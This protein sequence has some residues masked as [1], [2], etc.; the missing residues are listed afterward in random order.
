M[1]GGFEILQLLQYV[2]RI[3]ITASVTTRRQPGSLIMHFC[4]IYLQGTAKVRR[5]TLPVDML[6]V[7][8]HLLPCKWKVI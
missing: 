8:F 6:T 4:G 2:C 1:Q 5:G 7:A 3:Y